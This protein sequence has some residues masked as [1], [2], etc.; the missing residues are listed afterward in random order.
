M[1]LILFL[2]CLGPDD[3]F[4]VQ[5]E[6]SLSHVQLFAPP[7]TVTHGNSPGKNTGVGFCDIL[8][9]IFQSQ[10]S[11]LCVQHYKQI[12]YC[13]SHKGSPLSG[14]SQYKPHRFMSGFCLVWMKLGCTQYVTNTR[15][16][17]P[18]HKC[19]VTYRMENIGGQATSRRPW[20]YRNLGQGSGLP[21]KGECSLWS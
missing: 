19:S 5:I 13:L 8:Q 6:K 15:I 18:T 10:R 11:N 21:R 14:I 4:Q 12:L 20:S 16:R 17:L 7:W 3:F 9:G 2:K 1:F